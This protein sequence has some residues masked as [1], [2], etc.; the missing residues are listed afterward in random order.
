MRFQSFDTEYPAQQRPSVLVLRLD[1]GA[2]ALTKSFTASMSAL[3]PAE[4][5]NTALR[6]D[7]RVGVELLLS[8]MI[9]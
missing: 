8:L 1:I 4:C 3:A 7:R 5:S 6:C 2:G 9:T